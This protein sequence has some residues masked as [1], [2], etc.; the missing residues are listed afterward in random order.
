MNDVEISPSTVQTQDSSPSTVQTQDSSNV[1]GRSFVQK[2]TNSLVELSPQ[3]G[4]TPS[5][6]KS[7]AGTSQAVDFVS[8]GDEVLDASIN[9]LMK[10]TGVTPEDVERAV[11]KALRYANADLI[12]VS[13]IKERFGVHADDSLKLC[14]SY[15]TKHISNVKENT[16]KVLKYAH[17][18]AGNEDTWERMKKIYMSSAPEKT[19]QYVDKLLEADFYTEAIDYVVGYVQDSGMFPVVNPTLRGT[20]AAMNSTTHLTRESFRAEMN[21]LKERAKGRSL[22]TGVY[23]DEYNNLIQR[24][25]MSLRSKSGL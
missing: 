1:K 18:V 8:S 23:R 22:D 4:E 5:V 19:K 21:N 2:E 13:Y 20:T 25:S 14:N 16:L 24:Y 3:H 10:V 7:T 11:G 17:T 15:V 9:M 12:D 6:S